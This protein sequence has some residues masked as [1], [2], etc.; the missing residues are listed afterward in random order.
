MPHLSP[1][2]QLLKKFAFSLCTISGQFICASPQ[3]PR[4]E[5]LLSF[6]CSL[7]LLL[8][9]SALLWEAIFYLLGEEKH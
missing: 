9:S 4:K 7:K 3:F 2:I 1:L 6:R 8:S 5:T